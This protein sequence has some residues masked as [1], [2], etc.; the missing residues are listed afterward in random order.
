MT[1]GIKAGMS[2]EDLAGDS[3]YFAL[4]RLIEISELHDAKSA[5][6]WAE[7]AMD[8]KEMRDGLVERV[9]EHGG[10]TGIRG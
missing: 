2:P 6:E 3:V 4:F 9:K 8:S 7:M 5:L 1:Q 10:I